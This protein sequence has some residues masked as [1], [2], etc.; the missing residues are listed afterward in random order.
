MKKLQCELCGGIE[1]VKVADNMFQCQ[2]C[3]CKYT[4]DEARKLLFGEMTFIPQDFE[5]IGGK[6]VKYHGASTVVKIPDSVTV[7]GA[8]S[9]RDCSGITE[10]TI[11]DTV[12]AIE[13]KAFYGCVSLQDITIPDSVISLGTSCFEGCS[14]LKSIVIP[15][16][17]RTLGSNNLKDEFTFAVFE[18]CSALESVTLS[19]NLSLIGHWMFKNC[20]SLK[21]IVIPEGVE[22]IDHCAFTGC[23]VL[24]RLTLPFSLKKFDKEHAH[25]RWPRSLRTVEG[26]SKPFFDAFIGYSHLLN[27]SNKPN[28]IGEL[29]PI[30]VEKYAA[31][32]RAER[33]AKH[34]CE[35]CGGKLSGLFEKRCTAC[36]C[37]RC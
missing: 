26:N 29:Y 28:Y 37:V 13:S 10:V 25:D 8:E 20:K 17:V 5:I 22:V 12:K 11:P 7:I 33:R 6:L 16:S 27:G 14:S 23:D 34:V 4:A 35:S 19:H 31:Q 9:F 15:D 24:E 21:E 1:I 2:H 18:N 32:I 36:G 3:G 30:A